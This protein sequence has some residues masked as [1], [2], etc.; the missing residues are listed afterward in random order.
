MKI[1]DAII[2]HGPGRS[3]TTLVSSILSLH[4]SLGWISG[5]LNKYPELNCLSFLNR[6]NDINF[7]ESITR[8]KRR[9]P[10]P[11]EAYQYWN[12]F[13]PNFD[14]FS[15]ET[16][17][18]V[19]LI[20]NNIKKILKYSGKERFVTKLTGLSRYQFL[21]ELFDNPYIIWVDR[22]PESVILSYYK[23][24]WNYKNKPEIF[25]SKH[26]RDLLDEYISLYDLFQ[27]E[28]KLLKKFRFK[29]VEY[30]SLVNDKFSFFKEICE[31]T[32]LDYNQRFIDLIS[33]WEIKKSVDNQYKNFLTNDDMD[34]LITQLKN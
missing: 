5:Y 24:R 17:N 14:K 20:A 11:S 27:K 10:R 2:I 8:G 16:S 22:K 23:Q 25:K 34:Y 7:L 32:K 3:G 30:E 9:M 28:K 1:K 18:D 31:F 4:N 29:A 26:T 33:S 6:I 13:E 21:N 15:P 12:H 19:N